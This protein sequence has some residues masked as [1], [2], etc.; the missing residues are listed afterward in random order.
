V[1]DDTARCYGRIAITYNRPGK[2]SRNPRRG[3]WCSAQSRCARLPTLPLDLKNRAFAKRAL[4]TVTASP[5]CGCSHH[6]AATIFLPRPSFSAMTL[7]TTRVRARAS[8]P[9]ERANREDHACN[10]A[11]RSF[12]TE[13]GLVLVL[14]DS[15]HS[16][17]V[18]APGV[19]APLRSIVRRSR[20][21]FFSNSR[22]FVNVFT[23]GRRD[24]SA[25]TRILVAVYRP[26]HGRP[27][28]V[29]PT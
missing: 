3:R 15:R 24:W 10:T 28:L 12:P 13:I 26:R 6:R 1:A 29:I 11:R 19:G 27:A 16:S 21:A 17:P 2:P 7:E 9:C 22:N 18:R 23:S 25:P 4:P 5:G 14:V 20:S 8:V